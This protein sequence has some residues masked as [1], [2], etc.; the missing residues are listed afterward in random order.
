MLFRHLL[1]IGLLCAT[2]ASYWS[3]RGVNLNLAQRSVQSDTNIP[4]VN[5][6]ETDSINIF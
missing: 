4:T 5:A 3:V 1:L 6:C 2:P